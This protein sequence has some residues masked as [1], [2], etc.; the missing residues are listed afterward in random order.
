MM[1]EVALGAMA[2][3]GVVLWDTTVPRSYRLNPTLRRVL[4]SEAGEELERRQRRYGVPPA[5]ALAG[6]PLIVVDD[7]VAT[8][9]TARAALQSLREL[10]SGPLVLATPVIE[11]DVAAA[12]RPG[13][14]ELVSLAEVPRLGSVGAWYERFEQL[15]DEEVLACLGSGPSRT[16]HS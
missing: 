2:P 9:L 5:S 7:G 12:L 3:G 13:L 6:R 15:T 14:H 10:G 16:S 4:E 11:S 8:G 1:P